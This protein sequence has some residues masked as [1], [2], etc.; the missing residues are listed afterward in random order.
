VVVEN[1]GPKTV[2]LSAWYL[3]VGEGRYFF[4]DGRELRPGEELVV[5]VGAGRSVD[6]RVYWGASAPVLDNDHETL[7]LVDGDTGRTVR[8]S[9]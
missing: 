8:L 5:H 3:V 4:F 6:G 2:D 1:V 9:Y 7:K